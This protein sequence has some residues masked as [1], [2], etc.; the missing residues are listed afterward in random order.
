MKDSPAWSIAQSEKRIIVT[1]DKGF[2]N[3]RSEQ[4]HGILI[5]RLRKPNLEKI[6]ARVLDAISQVLE[7]E[8]P[9][10]LITIRDETK[11]VWRP[12]SPK[13]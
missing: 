11:A 9:G 12:N 2:A 3:R 6:H 5:V 8:W 10:L 13:R 7:T 4:H 1:T